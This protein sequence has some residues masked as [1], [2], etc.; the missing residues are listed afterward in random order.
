MSEI[1]R[2]VAA[3]LRACGIVPS[4]PAGDAEFLRRVSLDLTG[5]LPTAAEVEAF[6]ADR[7]PDKRARKIDELLDRPAYAVWWATKLCDYTGNSGQYREARFGP[8]YARQWYDWVY[9]RVRQN[10]GYDE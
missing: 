10:V 2:L 8:V 7:A 5:T 4:E 1:D 6:L 9:R 3:K